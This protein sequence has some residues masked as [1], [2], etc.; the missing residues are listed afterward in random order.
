MFTET[1]KYT[2]SNEIIQSLV[3]KHVLNFL[4]HSLYIRFD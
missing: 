3:E 1:L 4:Y 2:L